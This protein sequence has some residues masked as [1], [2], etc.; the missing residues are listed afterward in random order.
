MKINN[1]RWFS[2]I[3]RKKSE[4]FVKKVYMSETEFPRKERPVVRW[5]DRV[6]EYMLERVDDR[7][8]GIEQARKD[9][10][11]RERWRHFCGG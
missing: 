11:D 10:T 6:K 3:E 4:E 5:K 1:L 2:H 9:C 8:K 7:G